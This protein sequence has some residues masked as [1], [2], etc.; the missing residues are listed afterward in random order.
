MNITLALRRHARE[1]M[2]QAL[3]GTWAKVGRSKYQRATGEVVE[4]RGGSWH[5]IDLC[6]QSAYAAMSFI[7]YKH[8]TKGKE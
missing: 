2:A 6:W 7:D 1:Y 3:L 4:K 5:G 8:T